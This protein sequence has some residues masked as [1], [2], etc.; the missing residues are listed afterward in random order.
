MSTSR[1]KFYL[2]ALWGIVAI[3]GGVLALWALAGQRPEQSLG[4]FIPTSPPTAIITPS[5]TISPT[6][7]IIRATQRPGGQILLPTATPVTPLPPFRYVV[8]PAGINPITGLKAADPSLLE[9]RPVA[10]KI[11]TWP[12]SARKY[13]SGLTLA[14]VVYEYYTE[15]WE[16]RFIAVFYGRDAERAGPVRSGRYFDE[17]IMRMYHSTLVFA[18]ADDRVEKYLIE[19]PDLRPY[20]FL[21]R[22][23]NCP[24]L[25][26]DGRI[27]GYQDLFVN[28]AGVGAFLKDNSKQPLRPTF[29]NGFYRS[30]PIS[31]ISRVFTNYSA[32]SYNYW[33]YEPTQQKYLRYSDA[34]NAVDGKSEV[35]TAH[36]DYLTKQQLAADNVVVLFVPHLFKN[37]YD[38]ADQRFDIK[39]IGNG[40]AYIFIDG[41]MYKALWNRDLLDQ[42]FDLV[43]QAGKLFSLKPGVTYFQVID[44]ES[45]VD[46]NAPNITFNFFIPPRVFTPTPT[47]TRFKPTPTRRSH[48]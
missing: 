40:D 33:E 13:Q 10:V 18:N 48:E 8:A 3:L 6:T 19:S 36:I 16:T 11:V 41:N 44:L 5:L 35:Y 29:F 1:L 43:D 34:I 4:A 22:S 21:E 17:N 46:Q 9:R 28:T 25:C 23:D 24:P 47:P 27:E 45:T 20:L 31:K 26:R 7:I 37:D 14:D 32:Y 30:P 2:F 12:R 15:D 38:R 39:I 42:P